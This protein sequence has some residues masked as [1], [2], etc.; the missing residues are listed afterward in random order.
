MQESLCFRGKVEIRTDDK[1]PVRM[2]IC[3]YGCFFVFVDEKIK[4]RM[5]FLFCG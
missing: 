4:K 3:I 5:I 2:K 1:F